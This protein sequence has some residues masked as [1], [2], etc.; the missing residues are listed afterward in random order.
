M[1]PIWHPGPHRAI[2]VWLS[3]LCR[4]SHTLTSKDP[5]FTV[6]LALLLAWHCSLHDTAVSLVLQFAWH[7]GLLGTAIFMGLQSSQ[8][9][10]HSGVA[11]VVAL[12]MILPVV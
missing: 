1:Q 2:L 3:W 10:N 9:C 12:S 11:V 7:C 8:H 5:L 4:P 6:I